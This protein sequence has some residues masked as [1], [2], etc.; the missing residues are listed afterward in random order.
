VVAGGGFGLFGEEGSLWV[1]G[2]GRKVTTKGVGM[3][4]APL[5]LDVQGFDHATAL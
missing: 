2:A 5:K 4:I 1:L 3:V